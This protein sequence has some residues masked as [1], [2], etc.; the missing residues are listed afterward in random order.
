MEAKAIC[1]IRCFGDDAG[2]QLCRLE[3]GSGG[4]SGGGCGEII[5][6]LEV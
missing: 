3:R 4:V 6:L 2:E 5:G 1:V